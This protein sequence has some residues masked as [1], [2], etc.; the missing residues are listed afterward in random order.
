MRWRA[1]KYITLVYGLIIKPVPSIKI[2]KMSLLIK[3]VEIITITEKSRVQIGSAIRQLSLYQIKAEAIRTPID[4]N[5]SPITCTNA[6]LKFISAVEGLS[7]EFA[8][9][10]RI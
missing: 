10:V 5:R 9:M 4:W 1:Y 8:S 3:I 7:F 6:A 2:R